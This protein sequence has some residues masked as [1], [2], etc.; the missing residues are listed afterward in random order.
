[1]KISTL[2]PLAQAWLQTLLLTTPTT[3]NTDIYS[4]PYL[5]GLP[6]LCVDLTILS[7]LLEEMVV[8]AKVK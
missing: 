2:H 4:E 7:I 3:L 5:F 6:G 8:Y 1:M